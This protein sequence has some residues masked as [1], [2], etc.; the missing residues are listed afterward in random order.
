MSVSSEVCVWPES[1]FETF[2]METAVPELSLSQI[3]SYFIRH[4]RKQGVQR[5]KSLD[6]GQKMIESLCTEAWSVLPTDE[7][8][9]FTGLIQASMKKHVRYWAKFSCTMNGELMNWTPCHMQTSS[10]LGIRSC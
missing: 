10:M 2:N 9:F 3:T 5:I 4:G 7:K 6:K 8:F 1:G